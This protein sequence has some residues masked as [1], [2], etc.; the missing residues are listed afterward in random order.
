MVD[1]RSSVVGIATGYGLGNGEVGGRVP[2]GSR[3]VFTSSRPVVGPTQPPP[4]QCVPEGGAL[5]PGVKRLCLFAGLMQLFGSA[6]LTETRE[7]DINNPQL[8]IQTARIPAEVR[9]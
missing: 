4:F 6:V 5:S 2:M 8:L 3:I 1:S 7:N 9:T